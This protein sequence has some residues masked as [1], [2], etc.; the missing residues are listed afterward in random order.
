MSKTVLAVQK[1][2]RAV[3][4]LECM[5]TIVDALMEFES[6][7]LSN[8]ATISPHYFEAVRLTYQVIAGETV[9]EFLAHA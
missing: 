6:F 3:M 4:Y 9:A 1:K 8:G 7:T 5:Y 2:G